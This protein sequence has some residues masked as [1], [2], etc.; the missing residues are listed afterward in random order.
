[1]SDQSHSLTHNEWI[2]LAIDNQTNVDL[3]IKD[4]ALGYG[5][6]YRH[7]HSK[8]EE[9]PKSEVEGQIIPKGKYRYVM[10]SC[11]RDGSPTGTNGGFYVCIWGTTTKVA[12]IGW[13][14]P[15][16]GNN[17]FSAVSENSKAGVKNT[18]WSKSGSL[19]YITVTIGGTL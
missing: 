1:M 17:H 19:A 12:L 18:D 14:C 5:K 11:G 8:D 9:I 6:F 3:E 4:V 13:D 10:A 16:T 2:D 15:W 7:G